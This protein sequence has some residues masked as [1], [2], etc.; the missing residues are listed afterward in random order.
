MIHA[1]MRFFVLLFS[2]RRHC[3]FDVDQKVTNTE[4]DPLA[5][6]LDITKD[7]D[8]SVQLQ[9]DGRHLETAHTFWE[10]I[11]TFYLLDKKIDKSGYCYG[12]I[13]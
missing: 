3:A 9:H 13:Q 6:I 12:D 5:D 2:W 1:A 10:F 4:V 8:H 11:P 7:S